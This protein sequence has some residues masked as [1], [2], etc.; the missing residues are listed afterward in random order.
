MKLWVLV[1]SANDISMTLYQIL[2]YNDTNINCHTA[3]RNGHS[4]IL[5]L[6]WMIKT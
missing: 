1:I 3:P 2:A 6:S 4:K 5:M